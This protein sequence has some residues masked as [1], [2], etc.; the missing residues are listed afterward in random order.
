MV[1][2]DCK[3]NFFTEVFPFILQAAGH[4]DVESFELKKLDQGAEGLG[5]GFGCFLAKILEIVAEICGKKM[6]QT[7][8]IHYIY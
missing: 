4:L 1:S 2:K 7:Y 5:G 6:G 3:A 8:N